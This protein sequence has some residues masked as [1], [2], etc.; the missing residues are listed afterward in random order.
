MAQDVTGE[1][2]EEATE[3]AVDEEA[4]PQVQRHRE[5]REERDSDPDGCRDQRAREKLR[6]TWPWEAERL[7]HRATRRSAALRVARASE[8]SESTAPTSADENHAMPGE[9]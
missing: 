5:R 9:G 1:V 3:R 8:P 7:V 2:D 6:E 4:K